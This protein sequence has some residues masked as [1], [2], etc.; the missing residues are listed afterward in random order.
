MSGPPDAFKDF[1]QRYPELGEAWSLMA[2]AGETA[3]PLSER[4][5]R[6]VKL[7]VS[8]G[9]WQR[10][11]VRSAVRKGVKA[12]LSPDELE[13]GVAL[14]AANIGLPRSVAASQWIR[15]QLVELGL[16]DSGDSADSS[17]TED[18]ASS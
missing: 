5:Q 2:R 17:G 8:L 16:V 4:E 12:G 13:Q 10:S 7:G 18:G 15:E 9:I 6:L 11:V 14:A 3:G 1:V